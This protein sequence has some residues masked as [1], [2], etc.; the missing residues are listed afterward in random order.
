MNIFLSCHRAA[1]SILTACCVVT[2]VIS[3]RGLT[4][5]PSLPQRPLRV[6][7]R[8][9]VFLLLA[10][11]AFSGRVPE[12]FVPPLGIDRV[13]EWKS[14]NELASTGH[15]AEAVIRYKRGLSVEPW[16]A[17]VHMVLGKVFMKMKQFE[18]ALEAFD[19]ALGINGMFSALH[20]HRAKAL[21]RL[22][23]VKLAKEA[24]QRAIEVN[25]DDR[26]AAQ[27]LLVLTGDRDTPL[28]KMRHDSEL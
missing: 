9:F 15:L 10:T 21:L 28:K 8:Y 16:N 24:L 26:T 2:T 12:K 17:N 1:G 4:G 22:G 7:S 14:A 6:R 27:M 18:N 13:A 3:A 19:T 23:R 5:V 11:A 25:G 20:V